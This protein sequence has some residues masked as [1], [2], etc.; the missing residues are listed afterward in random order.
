MLLNQSLPE[1][2]ST[3]KDWKIG[4]NEPKDQSYR[5]AGC[6][7]ASRKTRACNLYSSSG[8]VQKKPCRAARPR[9]VMH[10]TSPRTTNGF[11]TDRCK[12]KRTFA[13]D[14]MREP[15]LGGARLHQVRP[16]LL[17]LLLLLLVSVLL[18][19]LW[20]D[21]SFPTCPCHKYRE[22]PFFQLSL[23]SHCKIVSTTI[24]MVHISHGVETK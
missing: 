12:G 10:M 5:R 1:V 24:S 6:A 11:S 17:L 7:T 8:K 14:T 2:K 22:F 18:C 4:Q 15:H 19:F 20:V 3:S 23:G 9:Q 21:D 13:S 16:L